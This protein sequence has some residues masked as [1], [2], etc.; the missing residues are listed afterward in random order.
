[1][2]VLLHITAGVLPSIIARKPKYTPCNGYVNILKVL[3]HQV[4]LEWFPK[5][6]AILIKDFSFFP[7]PSC[8]WDHPNNLTVN[9][10]NI[11]YNFEAT[12]II[13]S[14]SWCLPLLQIPPGCSYKTSL[15]LSSWRPALGWVTATSSCWPL[16]SSCVVV[17][18]MFTSQSWRPTTQLVHFFRMPWCLITGITHQSDVHCYR[19]FTVF[20]RRR[21]AD[22]GFHRKVHRDPG[23][24]IYRFICNNC[25]IQQ[26]QFECLVIWF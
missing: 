23:V 5:R 10:L 9:W 12:V 4:S 13:C 21:L 18:S 11:A 6:W 24:T 7:Y 8:Q 1:M 16:P 15:Q 26:L 19:C 2:T 25:H 14:K 17:W 20:G 3:D 22:A